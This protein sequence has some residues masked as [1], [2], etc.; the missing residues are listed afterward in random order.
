MSEAD[1]SRL[2]R[3]IR[4]S[5]AGFQRTLPPTGGS[6]GAV[7]PSWQ[8]WLASE[9][10]AIGDVEDP[11]ASLSLS[12]RPLAGFSLADLLESI[13]P[14][15][16]TPKWMEAVGR[17]RALGDPRTGAMRA[18]GQPEVAGSG[19]AAAGSQAGR[20]ARIRAVRG[21]VPSQFDRTLTPQEA[22]AAC[23]PAAAVAFA[24]A[25]GRDLSLR[26]AVDLART[27]GWTPTGGMNGVANQKRLLEKIGVSARLDS[28]GDWEKI[29]RTVSAGV[30]VTISTPG[31]YFVADEYDP[32]TGRFH[33][34][35]SGTAYRNGKEW[36]TRE[37]IE[38]AAGR[39]DGTLVMDTRRNWMA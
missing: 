3:E 29:V 20:D 2:V 13:I 21:L 38:G 30:P 11:S 4:S 6:P 19:P 28:S 7:D 25:S 14:T 37:E 23:G 9:R 34:G 16:P 8:E 26:Q 33:V 1:T 35:A 18:S 22:N 36:M 31:H 10:A 39:I 27:V 17:L 12:P 32:R 5:L 15:A 24:R